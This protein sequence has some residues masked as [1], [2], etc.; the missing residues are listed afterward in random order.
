MLSKQTRNPDNSI[1]EVAHAKQQISIPEVIRSEVNFLVLPFFA[2]WDKDVRNRTKSEY[3]AVVKRGNQRLEVLWRVTSDPEYGYPGP[4][5]REVHK[6]IEQI[7]S[8][9][10]IPI[11]N[12]I[13]IGSLYNLCKRMGISSLGGSQY[14]KIKDALERITTTSIKSGGTYYSKEKKEWIEE[15]FHLYERVVFKGRAL[16]NGNIADTNY[17][18]L[19]SWYLDN[20]NANYVKPID[21]EYYK[22]LEN[23]IAQR[24]Y[25]LLSVK[26]YGILM[27][28]GSFLSYK[29]STICELLPIT[30]QK[31]FSLAKKILDPSHEKL[32]ES[33]FLADWN[34]DETLDKGDNDWLIKY[35]PGERA[36]E[37]IE[38]F[39][40]GEQL[41]FDIS[42]RRDKEVAKEKMEL[43]ELS[44]EKSSVAERLTRR[45][46]TQITARKLTRAY[47]TSQIQ[48]QMEV[49]DW[50]VEKKSSLVQKN[51]AGFL[52]KAIEEDY[53]PPKEYLDQQNKKSQEQK[54][55]DRQERWLQHREELI[56]QEIANW[57]AVPLEARIEGRLGFWTTVETMSGRTPTPEQMEAKKQELIDS[58]PQ[59]DEDKFEYLSQ[60]YPEEPPAD[61]E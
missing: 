61:F 7:I 19:N 27:R 48:R 59:T 54:E 58:L 13:P 1:E 39:R 16:P 37:E 49:F 53:Q 8:E 45:G 28:R 57:D 60:N 47:S 30:R 9:F 35:Y 18:Y 17:L 36:K 23:P 2:L 50:L 52:R 20:I 3:T 6:A 55:K 26:F 25:E 51:P 29:Y 31:Y 24:L 12:P 44:A 40:V 42:P 14:R 32:K 34:W 4:F 41:E 43:T 15:I 33:G 5:D 38:R 10:P 46:I 11:Q 22:Y 56:R 21:W